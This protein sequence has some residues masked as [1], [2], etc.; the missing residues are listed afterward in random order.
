MPRR[1]LDIAKIARLV[2]YRP[3]VHLDEIIER[4]IDYWTV[5]HNQKS[6][7]SELRFDTAPRFRVCASVTTNA[8]RLP[9]AAAASFAR[10][11]LSSGQQRRTS[12]ARRRRAD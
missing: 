10:R 3:S 8:E 9:S 1:V 2:G 7:Q 5:D 12:V 4:V 11:L 6:L